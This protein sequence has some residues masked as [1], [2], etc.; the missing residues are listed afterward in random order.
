MALALAEKLE[1]TGPAKNKSGFKAT[2]RAIGKDARATFSK[3]AGDGRRQ[4]SGIITH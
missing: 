2:K 3:R 1:Q 4:R